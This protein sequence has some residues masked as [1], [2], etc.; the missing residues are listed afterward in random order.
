MRIGRPLLKLPVRFC[1]DTLAKEVSAL[2]AEAWIEHP[3]KYDGNIAVP[4][5]SPHGE[6][7]HEAF[8]PMAPTK[9]LAEC[10]YITEIMKALPSTWGRSRLMGLQA[11][12]IVP[13]HVD[14]HYYWRTHLR[15]HIPVITN[16]Q[17][18]FTCAGGTVHMQPGECWLLDSFYKHEVCNR[19]SELRIH[20]V[21]DTVGSGNIW[22]LVTAGLAGDA[23]ERFIAPGSAKGGAIDFEQINAPAIMSPWEMQSHVAYMSEWTDEQ[24]GR[25]AVLAILDRFV[26][27]W[28]GTWARY[29]PSQEG[30]PIYIRHLT[31]LQNALRSFAG[32][33]V[34]MRNA[35]P[36]RDTVGRF[37]LANAI[38]PAMLE[39]WQAGSGRPSSVRMTA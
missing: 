7:G 22:D 18:A 2:P 37:I 17:V 29:G 6:I 32:P 12:A 1:G 10:P 28:S 11:G 30:V 9:W 8:G 33:V 35:L 5:I 36:L 27:A 13:E 4:L 39:R 31:E 26:M 3:Q 16:P 15:V 38:S 19:G 24:P 34:I 23:D 25:D 20:L 14:V 21:M